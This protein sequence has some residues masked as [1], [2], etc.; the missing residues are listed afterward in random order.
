MTRILTRAH[1]SLLIALLLAACTST[2]RDEA[3]PASVA[4]DPPACTCGTTQAEMFGCEFAA[5]IRGVGAPQNLECY[6]AGFNGLG[7]VDG[8]LTARME[9]AQRSGAAAA[10][11][12]REQL[13]LGNLA[14]ELGLFAYAKRHYQ[15]AVRAD[16][17][18]S[19]E[20]LRAVALLRRRAS[21]AELARAR[22]ALEAGEVRATR[23]HLV[24]VV[25]LFSNEPAASVARALLTAQFEHER[26][27]EDQ[28]FMALDEELRRT[29]EP[30]QR[31]LE[32]ARDHD[33]KGLAGSRSRLEA[34]L[35]Y[36][37]ALNSVRHAYKLLDRIAAR[38]T[39]SS[40][41]RVQLERMQEEVVEVGIQ[42]TLEKA[43]LD[44]S[45]GRRAETIALV[46]AVLLVDPE[47]AVARRLR[48][49]AE[50]GSGDGWGWYLLGEAGW[51][52]GFLPTAFES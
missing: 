42:A 35:S 29:L 10:N 30:A 25:Q 47:H 1:L 2:Q 31:H 41:L 9:Y 7:A 26:S 49:R 12:Y 39:S 24:R 5:C 14:R 36:D 43:K 46:N 28:Q 3:Q 8:E 48:Q 38:A 4:Y 19:L 22:G 45:R 34:H 13:G 37:E 52:W 20:V 21:E 6:C 50:A 44:L 11:D 23:E 17:S 51:A 27:L 16:P 18:R 40:E 15:L 32:R 33:R